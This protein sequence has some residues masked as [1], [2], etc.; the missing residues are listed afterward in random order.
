MGLRSRLIQLTATSH[1][2]QIL[3]RSC[4]GSAIILYH[5]V[6]DCAS[7]PHIQNYRKK[8]VYALAFRRQID[9]L[10]S[11]FRVVPFS[12]FIGALRG[13]C[14]N[15]LATITF[16]DGYQNNFR[17]AWPILRELGVPF[18]I[19]VASDFIEKG[20][21]LWVDQLEVAI[22]NSRD[23]TLK[24]EIDG[25]KRE[26]SL[27]DRN[28]RIR[29]DIEIREILKRIPETGKRKLVEEIT[30][31]AGMD[32]RACLQTDPDY[33][34]LSWETLR[35][36]AASGLGEV[37]AHTR[38]HAILTRLNPADARSEIMTSKRLIEERLQ[39]ACRFF[40]YPN[41][42]PGDFDSTTIRLVH[43]AGFEAAVTTVMGF[44]NTGDDPYSLRRVPMDDT[45]EWEKFL[46]TIS[47][48]RGWWRNLRYDFVKPS[49]DG[50]R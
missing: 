46:I 45:D 19:F 47:G 8:H 11:H 23:Q 12:D 13:S 20:E 33:A 32:V 50:E 37:G 34:P 6:T 36:M 28:E 44:I 43:D 35:E 40:A 16:D 15:R 10:K 41:G 29:A 5:G 21:P 18:T 3:I 9:F 42:Q 39:R 31:Q 25:L 14:L 30:A 2:A 49:C 17:V 1:I 27:R 4:R 24:I 48:I 22:G 7:L 38:S 26:F